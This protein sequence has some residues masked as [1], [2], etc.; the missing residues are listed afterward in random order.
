MFFVLDADIYLRGI[1]CTLFLACLILQLSRSA[2]MPTTKTFVG[3]PIH[4]TTLAIIGI[5]IS[6]FYPFLL[7]VTI[8]IIVSI[9]MLSNLNYP[10]L[11]SGRGQ[12]LL[13]IPFILIL[14]ILLFDSLQQILGLLLSFVSFIYIIGAPIYGYIKKIG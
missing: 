11:K 12:L 5:F 8:I 4:I 7:S 10:S 6:T 13:F 2:F 9:L 14:G 1:I 3:L